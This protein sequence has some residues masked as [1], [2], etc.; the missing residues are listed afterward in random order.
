MR[1]Q[2]RFV[3]DDDRADEYEELLAPA[4]DRC[5]SHDGVP[6][7]LRLWYLRYRAGKPHLTEAIY[8]EAVQGHLHARSA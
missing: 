2:R 1:I 7:D 3:W 6:F 5:L 4:V 8:D